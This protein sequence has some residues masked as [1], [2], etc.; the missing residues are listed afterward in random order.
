MTTE[1]RA[2]RLADQMKLAWQEINKLQNE[3]AA[4]KRKN[5]QLIIQKS[6]QQQRAEA[7]ERKL[8]A[9][10]AM[11]AYNAPGFTLL[12]DMPEGA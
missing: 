8:E 7:A 6:Q 12:T 2:N 10:T 4:L 11:P 1:E 5:D 9:A 3:V